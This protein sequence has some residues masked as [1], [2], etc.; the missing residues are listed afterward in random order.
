MRSLGNIKLVLGLVMGL[1]GTMLWGQEIRFS[2][3]SDKLTTDEALQLSVEVSGMKGG[4]SVPMPN[5][6]DV[7]GMQK[8]GTSNS[9]NWF[10]GVGSIT[11]S[12]TYFAPNP[13]TFKVPSFSYTYGGVTKS[14]PAYSV[15]VT[16]GT[17]KPQQNQQRSPFGNPFASPFDDF[18]RDPF[19]NKPKQELKYQETKADYFLSINLNKDSCYVGEQVFG[20]VVLYINERDY[21]KINVDAMDIVDMQQRIKNTGFWQ[22]IIELEKVPVTR[23]QQNGKTYFAYTLYKTVLFPI[24]SGKIEFKDIDLNAKKL[25][26]ATNASPLDA[27]LGNNTKYEPILIAANKRS[28]LVRPLPPT[29]LPESGMVGKFKMEAS[30]ASAEAVTGD[31]LEVQ[32]KVSGSGNMAMMNPPV[33]AFSQYFRQDGN[34]SDYSTKLSENGYYGEKLFKFYLVPTR[35]GSYDLGPIKLYYFDPVRR[36]YDSLSVDELPI[37]VTGE[38]L[39]NKLLKNSGM[40]SFYEQ[41]IKKAKEG[42]DRDGGGMGMKVFWLVGMGVLVGTVGWRV[43]SG[44]RG[45]KGLN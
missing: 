23:V 33:T 24:K 3:N 19:S 32:V 45:R 21:G 29:D 7:K 27:F 10:N 20:E 2:I 4:G 41:N 28:L 14:S 39:A 40:D 17:G 31:N 6:P 43:W 26:V 35:P 16:K 22:E 44:R 42:L 34:S 13:G 1:W 37:K 38:D 9:Q 11:I 36:A 30:L 18:F 12:R 25:Y 15:K 5:F 8:A